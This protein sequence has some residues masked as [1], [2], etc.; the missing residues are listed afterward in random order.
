MPDTTS[1]TQQMEE[2]TRAISTL[3]PAIKGLEDSLRAM[4]REA[5]TR[6]AEMATSH[7]RIEAALETLVE[8]EKK[9][10]ATLEEQMKAQQS[11]TT[12]LPKLDQQLLKST[13]TSDRLEGQI[14]SLLSLL[15]GPA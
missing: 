1:N 10:Q 15:Q 11:L 4:D 12:A 9:I 5:L 13:T 3:L 8:K 6:Q 2:L 14:A 7:D